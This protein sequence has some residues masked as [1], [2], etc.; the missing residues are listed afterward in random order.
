MTFALLFLTHHCTVKRASLK[1]PHDTHNPSCTYVRAKPN[2]GVSYSK[3]GLCSGPAV[4]GQAN[5]IGGTT[6]TS[7]SCLIKGQTVGQTM[8][9]TV[10]YLQLQRCRWHTWQIASMQDALHITSICTASWPQDPAQQLHISRIGL[11]K[12]SSSSSPS[13]L[14]SAVTCIS[15]RV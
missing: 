8:P 5:L 14:I 2:Q 7:F 6:F 13:Q 4:S 10:S 12:R 1:D 15:N 11:N 3:F 9:V